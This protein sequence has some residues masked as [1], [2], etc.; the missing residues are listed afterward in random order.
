[1]KKLKCEGLHKVVIKVR[2]RSSYHMCTSTPT[3]PSFSLRADVAP[4]LE[5]PR[6]QAVQC[7]QH[8]PQTTR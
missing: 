6:A 5:F 8:R 1:M 3:R 7:R 4:D 2:I